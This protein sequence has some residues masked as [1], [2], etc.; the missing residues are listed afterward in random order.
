MLKKLLL[1]DFNINILDFENN[2]R[3]GNFLNRL[4][5]TR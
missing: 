4:F 5:L 1:A 2:E 3:V